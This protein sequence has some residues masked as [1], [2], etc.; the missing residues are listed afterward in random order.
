MNVKILFFL[1]ILLIPVCV[2][3]NG[4]SLNSSD[5]LFKILGITDNEMWDCEWNSLNLN[6]IKPDKIV[7][8]TSNMEAWIDIVGYKGLYKKNNI[9]YYKGDPINN[10]VVRYDIDT[11]STTYDHIKKTVSFYTINQTVYVELDLVLRYY[12]LQTRADGTEFVTYNVE[13]LT[14]Y[15]NEILPIA[16]PQ[17]VK[18]VSVYIKDC[19]NTFSPKSWIVINSFENRFDLIKTVIQYQNESIE[20]YDNVGLEEYT[21]KG[22]PFINLTGESL[23]MFYDNDVLRK[24]GAYYCVVGANFSLPDLSIT[25]YDIYSNHTVTDYILENETYVPSKT[26]HPVFWYFMGIIVILSLGINKM[27]KL[28]K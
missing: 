13:Y 23:S 28:F 26:F 27:W 2:A 11:G 21:E 7:S 9:F 1:F 22:Y 18:N 3:D 19:N 16:V 15:D 10:T 14:V 17:E 4:S 25:V 20:Y 12:E 24:L 5:V 6:K 8:S